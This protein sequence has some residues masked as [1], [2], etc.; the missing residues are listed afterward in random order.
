MSNIDSD[1]DNEVDLDSDFDNEVD[2]LPVSLPPSLLNTIRKNITSG[3]DT[4]TPSLDDDSNLIGLGRAG[5]DTARGVGRGLMMD[6]VDEIG[7]ALGAGAEALYNKF[8]PTDSSLR[9]Q[10][11]Q[12]EEP[13]LKD[14]Y[15]KN[16]QEIQKELEV[17][18]ERSPWLTTAGQIGGG[19]TSGSA[20][21]GL[22]GVG[23][24]AANTKSIMEI[25][26]NEGKLK[27]LGTLGLRGSKTYA[28]ALPLIA[29]EGALSSKEG[30][31]FNEG[32]RSKLGS[33]VVGSALFGLPMVLGMQGVTD[34]AAPLAREGAT[35]VTNKIKGLVEDT[36]LLRQMKIAYGYG[37]QGINPKSQTEMLKTD[38]GSAQNLTQLDNDRSVKLMKEIYDA[39]ERIGKTVSSSLADATTAGRM[40]DI[41]PDIQAS[42][43]QVSALSARYP[44]IA[45]NTRA[46][47]IFEKLA[48]GQT[49]VT[50]L[51]AKDL[52]DYMDAYIGKFKSST[53]TTPAEQGILSSLYQTR[54]QFS[55]KLKT[56]IPEYGAAAERYSQFEKLV[57]ETIIAGNRPVEI[58]DEF[59]GS[60]KN[61]DQKLFDQIKKLNQ[62]TTRQGSATQPIRESFVNTIK[63]LKTFEEQE[64]QRLASGKIKQSAFNRPMKEIEEQIKTHSDDAVARGAM[65]AL[66]PHTGVANTMA[67]AI[68]GTGETG[69]AMSLSSANIAGRMSRKIGQSSQNNPIAKIT[70]GIYNAPNDTVLA[71]SQ[72]LKANPSLSKYGDSLEQALNSTDS[73]RRNQVLFTIMQNPKARAFVEENEEQPSDDF[74]NNT[75]YPYNG[76]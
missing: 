18:Q 30:G 12:I 70:R 36:P 54:K 23:K 15:R 25:A 38:L 14:L 65:D 74:T 71:L 4:I 63:G 22:M 7:G 21:G 75:T 39:E 24:T 37:T 10:G 61:Q 6:S 45:N 41:A 16:Q 53:N 5:L 44:E 33:D 60:M 26:R 66:E 34:V 57:P 32:E 40:V 51:E 17:S 28:K 76:N 13:E 55:N 35:N 29:A 46:S 49:K 52:I 58:K 48:G 2:S 27:A 50:P 47:Q 43:N 62:G 1:F 72:K 69:R 3:I 68:T 20:L 59:F 9:D 73:N 19:I 67:K 56:S 64:L 11:F 8:N 42:L 31:L